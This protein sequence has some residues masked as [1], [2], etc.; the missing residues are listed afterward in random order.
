MDAIG[1][2]AEL[3]KDESIHKRM[4]AAVVLAELKPKDASVVSA[5]VEAAKD[6][7][8]GLAAAALAALGQIGSMKALPVMIE[9]LSR[10]GDVGK[11]A[12]RAVGA[13]GEDALPAVKE[14]L[15]DAAPEVRAAVAGAVDIRGGKQSLEI[16]L[17]GLR[18]QSWD[19]ANRVTLALR[20]EIKDLKEADRKSLL[21]QVEKFV[22]LKRVQEDETALRAGL[23]VLGFLELP[24]ATETLL[25]HVSSRKATSV[26]AEAITAL[27]FASAGGP[28]R[29]A[30]RR[31]MELLEDADTLVARS[32]RDTLTVLPL[33]PEL[34]EDLAECTTAANPEVAFWAITRLGGMGGKVA[35]K[36][37]VPVASGK[38]R[39]RA[40]AAAKAIAALPEGEKLLAAALADADEEVGAQVLA[41][42]LQPLSKKLSRKEIAA[43][44]KAG[45]KDLKDSVALARRK[46]DPVRDA[47]P[48]G[49][50][51]AIRGA[52]EAQVKKEPGKAEAL[53][54][55]LT[56]SPLG[57]PDD[58]YAY[59]KLMLARSSKDPHPKARQRD[60]ALQEL[61][62]LATDGFP[63][64]QTL[65]K[66]KSLDD[67]DR[68]YL[69]FH[70]A[71]SHVPEEQG[72]GYDLLEAL[73]KKGKGKLAKA[74][75][76]KLALLEGA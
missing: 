47:D 59:A 8:E 14:Y 75:K 17:E 69:G 5:L 39:T 3:L 58:R 30:L 43:L 10:S 13:L 48:Q 36:A 61:Q 73:S 2:I 18:G 22:E 66:E 64:A 68:Y 72:V 28:T 37:L 20:Q 50:V 23:K 67:E 6:P 46:L 4:A 54:A 55:L 19:T 57:T 15:K 42:A 9:S 26:R 16:A 29:K 12:A 34:A 1:K 27:R 40:Q 33:S 41:E 24:D 76:N 38:D 32:A 74:A 63:L 11:E 71:E 44:L 35:E 60:P 21:K 49:W 62:K 56:R 25:A 45:T 51:E 52:A 65:G 53:Y 31:L 70:F 7:S